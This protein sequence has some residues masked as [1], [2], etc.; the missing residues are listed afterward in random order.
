MQIECLEYFIKVA[1]AKSINAAS[2]EI[3]ISQ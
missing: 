2:Y 3:N 1:D